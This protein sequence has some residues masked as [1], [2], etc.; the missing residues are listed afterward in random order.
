MATENVDKN[1]LAMYLYSP[2]DEINLDQIKDLLQRG[3]DP[4]YHDEDISLIYTLFR[5]LPINFNR[6]YK[7][8][9]LLSEYGMDPDIEA[10]DRIQLVYEVTHGTIELDNVKLLLMFGADPDA[11]VVNTYYPP[12]TTLL[13]FLA[14]TP[15]DVYGSD[16]EEAYK[17]DMEEII[18]TAQLLIQYGADIHAVNSSGMTA[19]DYAVQN[20]NTDMINLLKEAEKQQ[21]IKKIIK[22]S[23]GQP[24]ELSEYA[25]SIILQ[26]GGLKEKAHRA[27]NPY[28]S[29]DITSRAGLCKELDKEIYKDELFALAKELSLPVTKKTS[30]RELCEMIAQYV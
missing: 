27:I 18:G 6:K 23:L 13:M 7:I 28:F 26:P 30:K 22:K 14:N 5:E 29:T 10:H 24:G 4:N 16:D 8:L 2:L 1:A 17:S 11:Y 12:K 20:E 25:N 19:M 3:A 21:Q 15:L 9:K